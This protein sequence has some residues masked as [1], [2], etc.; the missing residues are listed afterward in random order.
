MSVL[1]ESMYRI[2]L[3]LTKNHP[4]DFVKIFC[5]QITVEYNAVSLLKCP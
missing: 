5:D 1:P 4:K 2:E 3:L